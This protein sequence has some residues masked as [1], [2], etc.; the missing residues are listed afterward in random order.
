MRREG[1]KES[2]SEIVHKVPL[3]EVGW[4]RCGQEVYGPGEQ[5]MN[6]EAHDG[7]FE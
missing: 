7:A 4:G 2:I 5:L 1:P 3:S 6:E